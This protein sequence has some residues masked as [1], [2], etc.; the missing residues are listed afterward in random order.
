MFCLQGP[1]RYSLLSSQFYIEEN[2]GTVF[3]KNNNIDY[4]TLKEYTL[5]VS[6]TDS[7]GL[8][9]QL[10]VRVRVRDSN[11]QPSTPRTLT[12]IVQSYNRPVDGVIGSVEPLDRDAVGNYTC[13]LPTHTHFSIPSKP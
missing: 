2:T 5:T 6:V 12:I 9:S 10:Q 7:G 3:T 8:S 4:E 11:D 1:F 13:S